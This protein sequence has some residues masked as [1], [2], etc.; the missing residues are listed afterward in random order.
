M[1]QISMNLVDFKTT[2]L[3]HVFEEC[4]KD[5]R[6]ISISTCGSELVGLIP[7]ESI[8][9]AADYYIKRDRLL[10]LDESNKIKL[11]IVFLNRIVCERL[12]F[13]T[14]FLVF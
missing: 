3:H 11:V 6:E 9:M 12:I 1:A 7:L 2:N 5:A 4:E 8:L 10:I 13:L 14:F